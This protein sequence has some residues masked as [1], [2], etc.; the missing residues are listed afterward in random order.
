MQK[1]V[2]NVSLSKL[3]RGVRNF[4]PGNIRLS[5]SRWLGMRSEQ[6][7]GSFVQFINMRHGIRALLLLLRNYYVAYNLVTI[8][9]IISRYAPSNENHTDKYIDYV[10]KAVGVS[11]DTPLT[12]FDFLDTG[13]YLQM[14]DISHL[15][16]VAKAICMYESRY[17]LEF[18]E[19]KSALELAI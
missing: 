14:S 13:I 8:R 5:K 12:D 10:A 1:Q 3:T 6:T 15:Y 7:D 11:S 16:L 18:S 2:P 4:N 9:Q 19:Y 17:T